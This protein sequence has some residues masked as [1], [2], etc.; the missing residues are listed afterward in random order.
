MRV[1]VIR[2]SISSYLNN[3]VGNIFM[4]I[5]SDVNVLSLKIELPTA[6][7]FHNNENILYNLNYQKKKK[8]ND[9]CII[10]FRRSNVKQTPVT[11][12]SL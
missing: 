1:I 11:L 9:K 5:K 10:I 8:S 12:K 3:S 4:N 6:R 2:S 7:L